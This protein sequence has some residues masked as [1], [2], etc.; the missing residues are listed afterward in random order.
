MS[1][2]SLHQLLVKLRTK[3]TFQYLLAITLGITYGI[4][5]NA[6]HA[7]H[8]VTTITTLPGPLF[9]RALQYAVL[10]MM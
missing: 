5:L 2:G 10:P 7:G 1:V 8:T 6:L 3:V 9:L 4:A